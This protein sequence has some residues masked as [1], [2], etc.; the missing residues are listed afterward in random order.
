MASVTLAGLMFSFLA[1]SVVFAVPSLPA[2]SKMVSRYSSTCS[3]DIYAFSLSSPDYLTLVEL[4]RSRAAA[5]TYLVEQF[6][7]IEMFREP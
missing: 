7:G 5:C 1:M 3:W 4:V 6:H 2:I